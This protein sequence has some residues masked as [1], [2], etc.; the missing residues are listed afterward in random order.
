MTD[1][2]APASAPPLELTQ[3]HATT[4]MLMTRFINGH[5]CPKLA[6]LIV[7]HLGRLLAHPD[8]IFGS[9]TMYR[10]LEE[11]WRSVAIMLTEQRGK[12]H[13]REHFH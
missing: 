10:Q 3:L 12:P 7:Q 8:L 11:H 5:H 4:C 6:Q 9:R 13:Y 2:I 1:D